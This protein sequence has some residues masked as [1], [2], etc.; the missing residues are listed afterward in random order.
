MNDQ[1]ALINKLITKPGKRDEVISILLESAKP[2]Q[3]NKACLLYLVHKDEEDANAIWVVD[4]WTN[5]AGH[6]A[7]LSKT[8]LQEYVKKAMPM[9]EG[10]PDQIHLGLVGGKGPSSSL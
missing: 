7:E 3:D 2:F 1:F 6:E 8:Q 9:L 4:L 10:M 5:K